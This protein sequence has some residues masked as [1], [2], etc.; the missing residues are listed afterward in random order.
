MDVKR[1]LAHSHL[2]L[3]RVWPGEGVDDRPAWC[4]KLQHVISGEINYFSDWDMLVDCMMAMLP[5]IE[6]APPVSDSDHSLS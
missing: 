3:V 2:F 4:G 6:L 5:P 1:D